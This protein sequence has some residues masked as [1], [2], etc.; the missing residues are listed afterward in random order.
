MLQ[1]K[2]EQRLWRKQ[3]NWNLV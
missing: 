1:M 3:K 2:L